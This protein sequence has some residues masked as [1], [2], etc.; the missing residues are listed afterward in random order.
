MGEY[1]MLDN[2]QRMEWGQVIKKA[3]AVATSRNSVVLECILNSTYFSVL[4]NLGVKS[5]DQ[6][7]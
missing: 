6:A 3:R 7:G 5:G 1:L 2:E 4:A